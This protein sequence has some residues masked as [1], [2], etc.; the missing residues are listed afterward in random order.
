MYPRILVAVDGSR[1]SERS[2]REA[3]TLAKEGQSR[4]RIVHALDLVVGA[5]DSP[6]DFSDYESS[7]RK[8]GKKI[9]DRAVARAEGA[10]IDAEAKLLEVQQSGDRIADEIVRDARK[11]RASLIVIGTHGRRGLSHALLGSV[12]EAVIRIAPTT[13]L[14]IRSK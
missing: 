10:G 8:A 4:L 11:W 14:L 5:V 6:Y 7:L 13:V 1:T 2:L 3:I 9:L 12:A